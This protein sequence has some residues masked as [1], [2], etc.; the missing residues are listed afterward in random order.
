MP[1][2]MVDQIAED[3]AYTGTTG[4]VRRPVRARQRSLAT[5]RLALRTITAF[6][7]RHSRSAPVAPAAVTC[8]T[9]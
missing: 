7:L 3:L 6:A 8:C 2:T 9:R 5:W 1:P 4:R